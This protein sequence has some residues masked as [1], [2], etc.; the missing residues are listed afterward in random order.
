VTAVT[1]LGTKVETVLLC[2]KIL[3][4][5]FRVRARRYIP[6]YGEGIHE[7]VDAVLGESSQS[8]TRCL[9]QF[10]EITL[11]EIGKYSAA[12]GGTSGG[13]ERARVGV[14]EGDVY[15]IA[16]DNVVLHVT[17]RQVG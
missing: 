11:R 8:D 1:V 5:G 9:S 14:R 3:E 16:M 2:V 6:M 7:L 12:G 13:K 4:T 17:S 15:S 10:L